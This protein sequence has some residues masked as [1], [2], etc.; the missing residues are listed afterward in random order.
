MIR[1][2]PHHPEFEFVVHFLDMA[3]R[4]TLVMTAMGSHK[5]FAAE[6][7]ILMAP[8]TPHVATVAGGTVFVAL[9]RIIEI[10]PP[11]HGAV[12]LVIF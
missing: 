2:Q 1:A 7:P 3:T 11:A 9:V 10:L 8:L 5:E 6:R 4:V 12:G